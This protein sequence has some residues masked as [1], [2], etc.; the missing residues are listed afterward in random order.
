MNDVRYGLGFEEQRMRLTTQQEHS[1]VRVVLSTS[2]GILDHEGGNDG[3]REV[4]QGK[5]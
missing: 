1:N 3:E 5:Q 4:I 2:D